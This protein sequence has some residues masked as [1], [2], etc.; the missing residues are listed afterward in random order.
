MLGRVF[1]PAQFAYMVFFAL[2]NLDNL[3]HLK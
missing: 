3:D 2:T 1:F